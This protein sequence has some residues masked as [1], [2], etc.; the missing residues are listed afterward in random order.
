MV[1]IKDIEDTE[2]FKKC[3]TEELENIDLII[4]YFTASWCGPCK[5]IS[6]IVENIG[7]NNSHIKVLKIDVN[8]CE[9][10]SEL[11][12]IECMPT[13]KFFRPGELE[14]IHGFSGASSDELMNTI[15]ILLKND[16]NKKIDENSFNSI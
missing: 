9:D 2:C 13:F 14:S 7:E 16:L 5:Q 3:M 6:P 10:V 15:K 8:E 1:F 4:C 12:E 11:Y